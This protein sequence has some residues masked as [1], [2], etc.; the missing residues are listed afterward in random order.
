MYVDLCK[1]TNSNIKTLFTI[2]V[3]LNKCIF[4]TVNNF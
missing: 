1:K 4:V 2:G 3:L